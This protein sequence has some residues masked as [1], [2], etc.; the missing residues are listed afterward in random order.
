MPGEK[1]N[2]GEDWSTAA[3]GIGGPAEAVDLSKANVQ[4]SGTDYSG[5]DK[6]FVMDEQVAADI[7]KSVL[8]TVRWEYH[9]EP[10]AEDLAMLAAD[11]KNPDEFGLCWV[12][13]SV[14]TLPPGYAVK[15]DGE[16]NNR[17]GGTAANIYFA[18]GNYR[19]PFGV[20]KANLPK[21]TEAQTGVSIF[22]VL[23]E[24]GVAQ[25]GY[26]SDGYIERWERNP[27][28]GTLKLFDIP[29]DFYRVIFPTLGQH[30]LDNFE[31]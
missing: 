6:L 29:S 23:D 24:P 8:E 9:K 21:V 1:N 22:Y 14:P 4:L 30:M 13:F 31:W 5:E 20:Y 19:V 28:L 18:E 12:S 7:C 2:W 25:K 27:S 16:L 11:G 3:P 26:S 10:T 17:T 15:L